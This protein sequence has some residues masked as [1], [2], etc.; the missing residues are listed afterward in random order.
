VNVET[1]PYTQSHRVSPCASPRRGAPARR[2]T[3]GAATAATP[4]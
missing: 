3:N 2:K 4:L 1:M